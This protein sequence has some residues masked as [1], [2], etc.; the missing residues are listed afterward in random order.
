MLR[1]PLNFAAVL[2]TGAIVAHATVGADLLHGGS[3]AELGVLVT[4]AWQG[5]GI[6]RELVVHAAAAA[7]V[8]GYA[9]V[10]AYPGTTLAVADALLS[11]VGSTR[12]ARD[13]AGVHLHT[14]L[15]EAAALG[16]GAVRRQL[17]S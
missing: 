2:P 10:V 5:N 4:D 11:P 17:A 7:T 16:L 14:Y 8:F 12:F 15:P 1:R 9:E 6:G 13:A 3:T